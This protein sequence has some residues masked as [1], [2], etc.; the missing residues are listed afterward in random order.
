LDEDKAPKEG[1]NDAD[2][3]SD[4]LDEAKDAAN[5]EEVEGRLLHVWSMFWSDWITDAFSNL[6]RIEIVLT[7]LS[8]D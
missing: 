5:A 8:K 3:F 7:I 4:A 1:A 6:S 2:D